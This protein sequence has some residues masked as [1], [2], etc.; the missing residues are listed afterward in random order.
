MP[1]K[2]QADKE[3]REGKT[4]PAFGENRFLRRAYL[5]SRGN[6]EQEAICRFPERIAG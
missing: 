3:E 2:A 5:T 4:V 1:E 6:P